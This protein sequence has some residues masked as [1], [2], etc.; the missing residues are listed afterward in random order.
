M[1]S[2]YVL[3]ND[4]KRR[5]S[6]EVGNGRM[7]L[8]VEPNIFL[9]NAYLNLNLKVMLAYLSIEIYNRKNFTLCHQTPQKKA[10][11][12]GDIKI[13]L[14]DQK[15]QIAD[16]KIRL[17]W[18]QKFQEIFNEELYIPEGEKGS[19]CVIDEYN[20]CKENRTE[21]ALGRN[22]DCPKG[23]QEDAA[24][25][26]CAS[27]ENRHWFSQD[28][29]VPSRVNLS[30]VGG[31]VN[32][33]PLSPSMRRHSEYEPLA[34]GGTSLRAAPHVGVGEY[35][36]RRALFAER[37]RRDC[38]KHLAKV[39]Y[40][41]R[42]HF[43]PENETSSHSMTDEL[44]DAAFRNQHLYHVDQRL[45]SAQ[46]ELLL[47]KNNQQIAMDKPKSILSNRRTGSPRA[48]YVQD[49][50]P[51]SYTPTFMD[52]FSYSD[53]TEEVE[54]ERFKRERYQRD[55]QLQIEEKQRLQAMREEQDRREREL[56]N[57]RLEQQLLRM[58][59]EQLEEE[60]K[61]ARRSELMRRHS[62][63]MMRH[64]NELHMQQRSWR[65]HADSESG[66]LDTLGLGASALTPSSH[67][68]PPILHRAPSSNIPATSVFSE[69]SSRYK[70]SCF[71]S[72]S[73]SSIFRKDT[74][75]RMD[76]LSSYDTIPLRSNKKFERFDSLSR[77]DSLNQRLETMSV[78]GGL[79]ENQ[80]RHS[81][82]QQDL[83]FLQ[84]SPRLRRKNSSLRFE[85]CLPMPILKA[86]SPVAKEL[87]NA[88]PFSSQKVVGS[89]AMCRMEDR[90]QVPAIQR[91][92]IHSHPNSPGHQN[93][94]NILTQLGAIRAQLQREQLRMDET[95][96]K[97]GIA[98]STSDY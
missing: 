37:N 60:Q 24:I 78:C 33:I 41:L 45:T 96:R 95:L 57:K 42:T 15:L 20:E 31:A 84:R 92:I 21:N 22:E 76:S 66:G 90:W 30:P 54:R 10:K 13:F 8:A 23:N 80:R 68:S 69:S 71:Q 93:R 38:L 25:L 26:K 28:A 81:A 61:R 65:R 27:R 2:L 36:L 29:G 6:T 58:H 73:Y 11:M 59:E 51:T 44:V 9:C 19:S 17:E 4:Q 12:A 18:L 79:T 49:L 32:E 7:I 70:P 34:S 64:K 39:Q 98:R 5:S 46:N 47:I 63:N 52:G 87:R 14:A 67:Y 86:K 77:I 50:Y 83:N 55:L 43:S 62:D 91:N 3:V 1:S 35:E 56:E 89:D 40:D 16:E 88:I 75:N 53:P 94:S 72:S 85:D 97:R 82:T 74:L 48:R